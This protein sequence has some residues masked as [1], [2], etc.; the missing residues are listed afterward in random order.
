[1]FA[2]L[3]QLSDRDT[4]LKERD[5][6]ISALAEAKEDLEGIMEDLRDLESELAQERQ[7]AEDL[8]INAELLQEENENLRDG[9]AKVELALQVLGLGPRALVLR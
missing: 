6:A 4:L 7:R 3:A 5:T 9:L 1:M 8:S 2:A